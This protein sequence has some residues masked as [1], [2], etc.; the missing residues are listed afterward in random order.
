[1]IVPEFRAGHSVD[2]AE[3]WLSLLVDA[4]EDAARPERRAVPCARAT[5]AG[6]GAQLA[7]PVPSHPQRTTAFSRRN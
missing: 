1:M 5:L 2:T 4:M 7:R 3:A 6:L